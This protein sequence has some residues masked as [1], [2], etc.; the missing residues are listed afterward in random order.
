MTF[1][2]KG[3]R[4]TKPPHDFPISFLSIRQGSVAGV[5]FVNLTQN[6]LPMSINLQGNPPQGSVDCHRETTT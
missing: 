5:R 1:L 3:I 4:K 2:S 6:S